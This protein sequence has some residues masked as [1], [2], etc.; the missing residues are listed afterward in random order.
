MKAGFPDYGCC[1]QES[2][3]V[4]N[5]NDLSLSTPSTYFPQIP[6]TVES[7]SNKSYLT[8]HQT[9]STSSLNEPSNVPKSFEFVGSGK[10]EVQQLALS[11]SNQ[12]KL[13]KTSCKKISKSPELNVPDQLTFCGSRL[14]PNDLSCRPDFSSYFYRNIVYATTLNCRSFEVKSIQ[15]LVLNIKPHTVGARNPNSEYWTNSIHGVFCGI[16]STWDTPL[17]RHFACNLKK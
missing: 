16:D 17:W 5:F 6:E 9:L 14:D 12:S 2:K 8:T 13:S 3:T 10:P 7:C 15:R 4:T 11:T 1:I